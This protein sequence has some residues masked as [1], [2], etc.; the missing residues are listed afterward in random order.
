MGHFVDRGAFDHQEEAIG[1]LGKAVE[2]NL[3]HGDETRLVR[4]L[5]DGA[6]LQELAIKRDVH[7]AG[8]EETEEIAFSGCIGCELVLVGRKLVA[9][10]WNSFM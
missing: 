9:G 10:I 1:I 2:R 4:E 3:G 8:V 5:V 6:L 7:I